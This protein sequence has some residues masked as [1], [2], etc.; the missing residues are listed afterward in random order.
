MSYFGYKRGD[1]S[2][3]SKVDW[4]QVTRD[5]S[6]DLMTERQRRIDEKKALE[7]AN[8]QSVTELKKYDKGD[9]VSSNEFLYTSAQEGVR[10]QLQ[11]HKLMKE[12]KISVEEANRRK[13]NIKDTWSEVKGNM[14]NVQQSIKKLASLEGNGNAAQLEAYRD[15][16]DLKGSKTVY[17]QN[18]RGVLVKKDGS[19]FQFANLAN[20]TG[21]EFNT[22]D[23]EDATTRATENV[24]AFEKYKTALTSV[25][26]PRQ[27]KVM[28]GFMD[29]LVSNILVDKQAM[30]S[31]LM[32]YQGVEYDLKG[33]KTG[34]T[35]IT[36]SKVNG[37][38]KDGNPII[39]E[40][41]ADIG[42]IK[43]TLS[44]STGKLEPEL[45]KEQEDLAK[46]ITRANA[47]VKLSRKATKTFV[48]PEKATAGEK[49][50]K[51]MIQVVNDF[52]IRGQKSALIDLQN[53]M[54]ATESRLDKND[55]GQDV[56]VFRID[57]KEVEIEL[58]NTAE[59]GRKIA[60]LLGT[61]VGN[62][63]RLKPGL[64]KEDKISDSIRQGKFY[65]KEEFKGVKP[66]AFGQLASGLM[67]LRPKVAMTGGQPTGPGAQSITPQMMSDGIELFTNSVVQAGL[68]S[69]TFIVNR[70]TGNITINIDTPRGKDL[71][72]ELN[73]K[74][75]LGVL[76]DTF[77]PS[78]L[79]QALEGLSVKRRGEA[80]GK[81]P[82]KI[83]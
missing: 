68:P 32:D 60:Q 39:E 69:D 83:K 47:E 53:K 35:S 71:S 67:K 43:M 74:V 63:Y 82:Y 16:L 3:E 38:D 51:A 54:G 12:G 79:Q 37:Y 65:S 11:T 29:S 42:A 5:I 52:L 44:E 46:A 9:D 23:L 50:E 55:K 25:Q 2:D 33:D 34:T 15:A 18:G 41:T 14:A 28:D 10:F 59:A 6:K 40:V 7:E 72:D 49:E 76:F 19:T 66:E 20:L 57:D 31:V 62:A 48:R 24:A 61:K 78:A 81:V 75:E 70:E 13:L 64:R 45:N 80:T 26:D 77:S 56:V 17:D 73:S 30:A 22:V 36:Y 21:Q 27:Q 58:S 1:I 8:R 4:G